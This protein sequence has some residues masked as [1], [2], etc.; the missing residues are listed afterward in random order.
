MLI[1]TLEKQLALHKSL[2][3]LARAKKDAIKENKMDELNRIIRDEQKHVSAVSILEKQRASQSEGT[4]TEEIPNLLKE[5]QEQAAYLRDELLGVLLELK[6]ANDLNAALLDQS[7]QFVHLQLD[8]LAPPDAGN[9]A[10]D[11]DQNEP[12]SRPVFD[13]KA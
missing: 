1:K 4:V 8:L 5:E 6:E 2:L 7:L 10:P 12:S 11:G 13:S 9:Y 3:S